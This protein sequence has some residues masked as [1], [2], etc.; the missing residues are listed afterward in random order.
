MLKVDF[1][2]CSIWVRKEFVRCGY[3]F[4]GEES[5]DILFRQITYL[6]E[7]RQCVRP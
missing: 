6:K 7:S 4:T 1:R 5:R 3:D 2:F